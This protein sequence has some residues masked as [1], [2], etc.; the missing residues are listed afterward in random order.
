MKKENLI[1]EKFRLATKSSNLT[2]YKNCTTKKVV[3]IKISKS[4]QTAK[5]SNLAQPFIQLVSQQCEK[6]KS[7][8]FEKFRLATKS[9]NL[10]AGPSPATSPYLRTVPQKRLSRLKILICNSFVITISNVTENVC[11]KCNQKLQKVK[12]VY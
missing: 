12:T 7:I 10:T 6:R 1:F 8:N 11:I 9:S 4:F 5:S 3:S 2:L